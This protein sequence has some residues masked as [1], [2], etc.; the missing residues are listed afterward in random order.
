MNEIDSDNPDEPKAAEDCQT[1]NE[2]PNNCAIDVIRLIDAY[3]ELSPADAV[4]RLL[5]SGYFGFFVEIPHSAIVYKQYFRNS[6]TQSPQVRIPAEHF[7]F[8]AR[9]V[10]LGPENVHELATGKLTNAF[11]FKG[12]LNAKQPDS[13]NGP[14]QYFFQEQEKT[15]LRP[16][17]RQ[18]L[19]RVPLF[20]SATGSMTFARSEDPESGNRSFLLANI[21][22]ADLFIDAT[23]ASLAK[24]LME[25]ALEKRMRSETTDS[26]N[27]PQE[28][29]QTVDKWPFNVEVDDP[30][31]FKKLC[32]F[33][34][35]AMQIAQSRAKDP[36]N[37]TKVEDILR[38]RHPKKYKTPLGD[39]RRLAFLAKLTGLDSHFNP[40]LDWKKEA[41]ASSE[42]DEFIAQDCY[43]PMLRLLITIAKHW[44]TSGATE[45]GFKQVMK[46]RH[47]VDGLQG[48]LAGQFSWIITGRYIP[49]DIQGRAD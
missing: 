35:E 20:T 6:P 32:P 15:L 40:K 19:D 46:D 45:A 39:D 1:L 38:T 11:E 41:L 26:A 2:Y 42:A 5:G 9:Y 37:N 23:F 7:I 34:F 25:V 49:I 8:S 21:S 29:Q 10:Q 44:V 16:K 17:A 30:H 48:E 28:P 43:S 33:V 18:R 4:A 31:N 47:F 24:P 22:A 27:H 14:K 36:M 3:K 13:K 12:C